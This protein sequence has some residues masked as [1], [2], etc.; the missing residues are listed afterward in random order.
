MEFIKEGP[1]YKFLRNSDDLIERNEE[2]CSQQ[3]AGSHDHIQ[4]DSFFLNHEVFE[5][6]KE[7]IAN[8]QV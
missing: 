6:G 2:S 7:K 5:H 8:R 3:D 4:G 1:L